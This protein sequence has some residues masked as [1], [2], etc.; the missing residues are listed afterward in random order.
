MALRQEAATILSLPNELLEPIFRHACHVPAWILNS[1]DIK[2]APNEA[3]SLI[4]VCKRFHEVALPILYEDPG[5]WNTMFFGDWEPLWKLL[6]ARSD[7]SAMIKELILYWDAS[8]LPWVLYGAVLVFPK[9][10]NLKKLRFSGDLKLSTC[11]DFFFAVLLQLPR[12]EK[13]HVQAEWRDGPSV[14]QVLARLSLPSLRKLTLVHATFGYAQDD[15]SRAEPERSDLTMDQHEG[16]IPEDNVP[17]GDVSEEDAAEG[18]SPEE[19]AIEKDVSEE[20]MSEEAVNNR[21]VRY[22][23]DLLANGPVKL[24]DTGA[25]TSLR[26]DQAQCTRE[27]LAQILAWPRALEHFR[28]D[29][30]N[31]VD[32]Y[33]FQMTDFG[34]GFFGTALRPQLASLKTLR[35]CYFFTYEVGR[36]LDMAD[37]RN[38]ETLHTHLENFQHRSPESVASEILAPK[39]HTI[40]F[41]AQPTIMH[42]G[43]FDNL[44]RIAGDLFVPIAE[45][46]RERQTALKEIRVRLCADHRV[47][48]SHGSFNI[49]RI[50]ECF[51]KLEEVRQ[52]LEQMGIKI[53]YLDGPSREDCQAYHERLESGEEKIYEPKEQGRWFV[54]GWG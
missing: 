12:L 26:I 34:L 6:A 3:Y 8:D 16:A 45:C 48:I 30:H 1:P 24:E 5:R 4:L 20:E 18:D 36:P 52:L 2:I 27:E 11:S 49:R 29:E 28:Y 40:I 25:V 39:L 21:L 50:N 10:I 14:R 17:E 7:L 13:L 31:Q 19:T 33:D 23:G 9:M 44:D 38:L 47:A 35:L 53:S 41:D 46:A 37:F 22:I 43:L 51:D 54:G 15:L 32:D 42:T